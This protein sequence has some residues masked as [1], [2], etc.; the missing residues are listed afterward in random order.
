L[1]RA[2]EGRW[3]MGLAAVGLAVRVSLS[4]G[5]ERKGKMSA[6]AWLAEWIPCLVV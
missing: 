1:D 2:Q 6:S 4:G 3:R 5:E